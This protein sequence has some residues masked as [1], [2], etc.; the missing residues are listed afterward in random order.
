LVLKT[1]DEIPDRKIK[2]Y[3]DK[4]GLEFIILDRGELSD[5]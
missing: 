2:K 1:L 5:D 3:V 4:S